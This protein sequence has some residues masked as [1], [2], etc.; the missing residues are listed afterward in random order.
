[1]PYFSTLRLSART[2]I[3]TVVLLGLGAV[4]HSLV[5]IVTDPIQDPKFL[6]FAFLTLVTGSITVRLPTTSATVSVSETFVFLSLLLFG[7]PAGTLIVAL[8]VLIISLWLCK[9]R[10]QPIYRM[11][12]N[13][14]APSFSVWLSATVFFYLAGFETVGLA[15][16]PP[17]RIDLG[18]LNGF[19]LPL[20]AFAL[21][22]F[23]L[24]S[25]LVAWAIALEGKSGPISVWRDSFLPLALNFFTGASTASLVAAFTLSYSAWALAIIIPPVA[26]SYLTSRTATIRVEEAT[27]HVHALHTLYLSTIE[28]LAMAI[29]AGDQVTHGHIRRVQTAALALAAEMKV[30]DSQ[31]LKA[32]QAAALLHDIGKLAVPEYILNKPSRLTPGEYDTMKSHAA[33]GAEILSA[34]AFPYPVT[35]IVRHHHENWDGTGYP[36]GLAGTEIPI[37]ARILA[38]VDCY[39]ALTSDRP[40]RRS[41]SKENALAILVERRGSMYDPLVVDAFLRVVG[42]LSEETPVMTPLLT[43]GTSGE[44]TTQTRPTSSQPSADTAAATGHMLALL[45]LAP[46]LTGRL[47]LQDAGEIIAGRLLKALSAH[48]VI[49]YC[50]ED[51]CD[52]IVPRLVVGPL[53]QPPGAIR[54]GERLSGWVAANRTTLVNADPALDLGPGVSTRTGRL[55]SALSTALV[56]DD[57]L[58]GVLTVCSESPTAFTDE[59]YRFME[60]VSRPISRI[61]DDAI[62]HEQSEI[63]SMCDP[64]TG[65]PNRRRV[66]RLAEHGMAL[67]HPACAPYAFLLVRVVDLDKVASSLGQSAVDRLLS[68]VALALRSN[69]RITDVLFRSGFDTFGIVLSQAPPAAATAFAARLSQVAADLH[70]TDALGPIRLSASVAATGADGLGLGDLLKSA[71]GGLD[72]PPSVLSDSPTVH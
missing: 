50:A 25:W 49:F 10:P 45:E 27:Q 54:I 32:I 39:D 59:H 11:V 17:G 42:G 20:F 22:Y 46:S 69:L 41:L 6:L 38:V 16:L 26:L 56:L 21:L 9:R 47:T 30:E 36:D 67:N 63:A 33:K 15:R 8:D 13:A 28:T 14:A 48:V 58:V 61:I 40:Y 71:I 43:I 57:R 19:L 51:T 12:F 3:A 29:D 37:G 68:Q 7:P 70:L 62:R 5:V 65:L 4:V 66:T 1:M 2:Y 64:A 52:T 18:S 55:R 23:L 31:T 44:D 24:N 35:P 53:T 34:I 72:S 60:A